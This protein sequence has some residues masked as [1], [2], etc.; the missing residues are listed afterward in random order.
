MLPEG[1]SKR[2]TELF[3][4]I[5]QRSSQT[6]KKKLILT[7]VG[8]LRKITLKKNIPGRKPAF[9]GVVMLSANMVMLVSIL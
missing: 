6:F 3:K 5:T 7:A 1:L 4:E 8:Y 9:I 2:I